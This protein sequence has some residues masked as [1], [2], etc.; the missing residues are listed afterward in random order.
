MKI[1]INNFII[2]FKIFFMEILTN[3]VNKLKARYDATLPIMNELLTFD[4]LN[5]NLLDINEIESK[6]FIDSFIDKKFK[7]ELISKDTSDLK[8]FYK[9][10]ENMLF[11][12]YRNSFK[13]EK[14]YFDKQNEVEDVDLI[15]IAII[16]EQVEKYN[17]AF[18]M[19]YI[20]E[21]HLTNK[22][23]CLQIVHLE[24]VDRAITQ[25]IRILPTNGYVFFLK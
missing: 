25:K 21:K 23:L 18:K 11:K 5:Q 22:Q 6:L 3:K 20:I 10:H 14:K 15:D 24:K 1:C 8:K 12:L 2:N 19:L 7:Q 13:S 16:K 4:S 17:T 9:Q